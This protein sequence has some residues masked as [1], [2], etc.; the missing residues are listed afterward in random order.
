MTQQI[1]TVCVPL[2]TEERAQEYVDRVARKRRRDADRAM[3]RYQRFADR[4]FAGAVG[5]Y[6]ALLLLAIVLA[7]GR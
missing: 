4:L 6:C 2:P 1:V 3:R 7:A 5:A